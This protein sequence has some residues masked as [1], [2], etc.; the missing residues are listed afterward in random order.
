MTVPIRIGYDNSADSSVT[1]LSASSS[2][3]SLTGGKLLTDDIQ[4]IW[5]AAASSAW[6][7]LDHGSAALT[8]GVALMNSNAI[9]SD[10]WRIRVSSSDATGATG[11]LYDSGSILTPIDVRKRIMAHFI[12]PAVLGRYVRIDLAQASVAQAGRLFVGPVWTPSRDRAFGNEPLWRDWSEITRTRGL[13]EIRDRR[14]RQK[15]YAFSLRGLTEAEIEGEIEAINQ[16][17]GASADILVCLDVN[18]LATKTMWGPMGMMI[19]TPNPDYN[20]HI[21][22]FQV[23]NRL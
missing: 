15:G 20:F 11:D 13:N 7:L 23:W 5:R 3:G 16:D 19:R 12:E 21:A 4:E 17:K 6:L 22:E 2:V 14:S 18:E 10:V 1:T 8:G 9:P